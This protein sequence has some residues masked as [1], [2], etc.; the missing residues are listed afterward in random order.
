MHTTGETFCLALELGAIRNNAGRSILLD[1][2]GYGGGD[3]EL[4]RVWV[5]VLTL[6]ECLD[7][8]RTEL[9]VLLLGVNT[10]LVQI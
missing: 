3:I 2:T 4:V 6:L 8:A 10:K 7:L 9:V 1:I 5:G